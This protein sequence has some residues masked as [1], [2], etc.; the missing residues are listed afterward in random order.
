MSA[1]KYN[2]VTDS[3]L[4]GA[5][6][7]KIPLD[8]DCWND[9]QTGKGI[10]LTSVESFDKKNE[11]IEN[12]LQSEFFGTDFADDEAFKERFRCKC[13]KYIGST[14]RGMICEKCQTEV[15]YVDIDL[16]KFGWIVLDHFVLIAPVYYAK[17]IDALGKVDGEPVIKHILTVKY[18]DTDNIE[19][20]D[21]ELKML[22][23]HPYIK[24]GM[25]WFHDHYKEVLEYYMHQKSDKKTALFEE[26]I[27][28]VDCVFTHCIPVFS[29][30]LRT[31]M[32]N[33]EKG[34]KSYK[35]KINTIY[36][37]IIKLSNS[38][39]K[40]SV[41]DMDDHVINSV[42]I[43]LAA[44][45]KEIGVLFEEIV[46][47][48][49][50]KTGIINGKVLG[51]RYN[52][53]SRQI[54]VPASGRIRSDEIE[55]G[56]LPFLE[57]YRYEIINYY[58]KMNNCT[59]QEASYVWK[60]AT[61]HFDPIIFKIM[62]YMVSSPKYNKFMWVILNRNPSINYGSFISV[63][64]GRVKPGLNDKTLGVSPQVI[65][66]MNADFDGDV[67]NVYRIVGADM[68]KDIS[69]NLRPSTNLFVSRMTGKANTETLPNKE[70]I[71]SF[72]AFNNI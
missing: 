68:A 21:K 34:S 24:K 15:E 67:L 66:P 9:F 5:R 22:K 62:E 39:N 37:S 36:K 4:T 44:A 41:T 3:L 71:T 28:E 54:I 64:V 59:I 23:N 16:E 72:W 32:P 45:Q 6:V 48:M 63:R 19:Y 12:G 35:L 1:K 2:P 27:N 49:T 10:R 40:T 56:Y 55:M 18:D 7:T 50:S 53:S 47:T 33:G 17:L 70:E 31:E 8:L 43:K 38:I 58:A 61:N 30:V 14:Y 20:T 52:F 29:S 11:K 42:N 51:G 26:L 69:K 46:K 60:K 65:I 25:I 13:G 57:L